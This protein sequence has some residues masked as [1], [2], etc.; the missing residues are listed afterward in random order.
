MKKLIS[1]TKRNMKEMLRD[2]LS[3]VFCLA[4]PVVML[5]LMQSIFLSFENILS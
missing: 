5:V 4:F 3:L 1:L 2:P